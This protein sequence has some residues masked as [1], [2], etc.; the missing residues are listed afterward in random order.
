MPHVPISLMI[1]IYPES[2]VKKDAQS[3][4]AL[5]PEPNAMATLSRYLLR[6]MNISSITF[7]LLTMTVL[8]LNMIRI[9]IYTFCWRIALY[10]TRDAPLVSLAIGIAW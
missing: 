1:Q 7:A 4:L 3:A 8:G 5:S 6:P 10:I 9:P 2:Q